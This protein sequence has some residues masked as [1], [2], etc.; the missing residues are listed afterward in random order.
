MEE[1]AKGKA[2]AVGMSVEDQGPIE[3]GWT[4]Q[5]LSRNEWARQEGLLCICDTCV[6]VVVN[7]PGQ[8]LQS[9]GFL[10]RALFP[11]EA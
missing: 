5:G 3:Q 4:F 1:G 2:G 11:P 10:D 9:G 6:E 8:Q 7:S